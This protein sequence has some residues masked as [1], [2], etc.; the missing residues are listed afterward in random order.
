MRL[1]LYKR[2]AD[3]EADLESDPNDWRKR[4]AFAKHEEEMGRGSFSD[5][6]LQALNVKF[7]NQLRKIEKG[8]KRYRWTP[9]VRDIGDFYQLDQS[10]VWPGRRRDTEKYWENFAIFWLTGIYSLNGSGE[11]PAHILR[12]RNCRQCSKLFYAVTNR[13]AHCH[14]N[15]RQ[16]FH[17]DS[18]EYRAKRARYMRE[19]YRPREK[20]LNEREKRRETKGNG[21]NTRKIARRKVRK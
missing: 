11:S 18:P 15:C 5:P 7:N 8:L 1:K 3:L 2:C 4:A 12:F 20:E 21:V 10:F 16:K 13:Q 17:A 9:T 6:E 19:E 14:A